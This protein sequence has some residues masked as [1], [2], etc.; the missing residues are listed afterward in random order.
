MLFTDL[1]IYQIASDLSRDIER[2]IKQIPLYWKINE[3]N[4]VIRSASSV[5]PNIAEGFAK[6]VYPKEY[7]RFL[8]IALGSSDESQSHI[9]LLYKKNYISRERYDYFL[10][11]YK[12]LS[13][14]ILNLIKSI[15]KY[16]NISYR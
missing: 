7:I 1:R 11:Q 15:R 6:Q 12:N 2:L 14:K 13:I 4:Q 5:P 3:G 9:I 16:H 10:N 8:N